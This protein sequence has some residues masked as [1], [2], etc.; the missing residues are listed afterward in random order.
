M[1]SHH[2]K[3]NKLNKLE[4]TSGVEQVQQNIGHTLN[5][6]FPLEHVQQPPE[7]DQENGRK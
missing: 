2:V 5:P 6:E 4:G 1:Y 7:T 3:L